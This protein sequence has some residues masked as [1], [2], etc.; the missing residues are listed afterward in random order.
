MNRADIYDVTQ[1]VWIYLLNFIGNSCDKTWKV[2]WLT[3]SF[4]RINTINFLHTM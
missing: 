2:Y 1:N 4:Y 3:F